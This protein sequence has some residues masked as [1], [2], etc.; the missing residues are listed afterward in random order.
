LS[1]KKAEVKGACA[2][3]FAASQA[4]ATKAAWVSGR[5]GGGAIMRSEISQTPAPGGAQ[6][7]GI[8][9][10]AIEPLSKSTASVARA[11]SGRRSMAGPFGGQQ[12][13]A[14]A[15]K[16][17]GKG[18]KKGQEKA[19]AAEAGALLSSRLRISRIS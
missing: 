4:A 17:A 10:S 6:G 12:G 3:Q 9:A 19:P 8:V 1:T 2:G 14:C 7:E 15:S 16:G 13:A 5:G 18:F 11:S